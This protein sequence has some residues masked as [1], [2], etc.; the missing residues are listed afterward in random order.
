M[1]WTMRLDPAMMD[2]WINLEGIQAATTW[3]HQRK[4]MC[5]SFW[6]LGLSYFWTLQLSVVGLSFFEHFFRISFA[7]RASIF[8][9]SLANTFVELQTSLWDT[10]VRSISSS[11]IVWKICW[12]NHGFCTA[13]LWTSLIS[14][15][16]GSERDLRA[17]LLGS[18]TME[19]ATWFGFASD[20]MIRCFQS[21][22]F[23]D[24]S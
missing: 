12:E 3:E 20:D 24:A 1:R 11:C 16:W 10:I 18:R 4:N 7:C 13:V 8:A 22:E 14:A 19:A 21:C 23:I 17:A 5:H 9:T 6:Q 15:A 2:I